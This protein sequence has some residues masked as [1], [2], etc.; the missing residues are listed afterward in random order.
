MGPSL[1]SI[2]AQAV[3]TPPL[4][5][6]RAHGTLRS[7]Y[8]VDAFV[9]KEF[10]IPVGEHFY[11]RPWGT[12]AAALRRM[13]DDYPGAV[14]GVVESFAKDA[15]KVFLVKRFIEGEPLR[16]IDEAGAP[17][18]A[19]TLLDIHARGIIMDD[20]HADNF[21]RAPSGRV[22]C[23]D[24][25]RAMVFGVSPAP[26]IAVGRELAKLYREGFACDRNAI[27][28][29]LDS[30]FEGAQASWARRVAIAFGG[31]TTLFLRRLRKGRVK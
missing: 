29:F 6:R 25:G 14:L 27:Q 21:L 31:R 7:V 5:R 11:R 8:H 12:E 4:R 30:Y 23:I 20:A 16:M 3:Q 15:H 18:V 2:I 26:A 17:D 10:D 22:Y 19:R 13:G 9:V 1:E 24:F 28:P